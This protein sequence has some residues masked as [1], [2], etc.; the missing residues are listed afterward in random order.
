MVWQIQACDGAL[1][2]VSLDTFLLCTSRCPPVRRTGLP[3]AARYG[4]FQSACRTRSAS[5]GLSGV[6]SV[7]VKYVPRAPSF[8]AD[9]SVFQII[10]VEETDTLLVALAITTT[11]PTCQADIIRWA[12]HV[13][14]CVRA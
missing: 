6:D 2:V 14:L 12:Y 5:F 8:C 9:R 1:F 13:A 3:L 4:I 11:L 10:V 7:E